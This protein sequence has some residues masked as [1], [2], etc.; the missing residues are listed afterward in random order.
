MISLIVACDD[1]N[2]IGRNNEIPWHLSSDLK[3]FKS[4]TMGNTIIMG[5][6]TWLSL[7]VKPL[8][9]RKNIVISSS[10]PQTDGC[11]VCRNID[12]AFKNTNQ[13]ENIF[14][15]GGASIYNQTMQYADELIVTHIYKSFENTD[16]FFPEI[17]L[18][19]WIISEQSD[20]FHDEKSNLNYKYITYKRI[21]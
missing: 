4:I 18:S 11:I 16:A 17:K 1:N 8:K 2:A 5:K 10:M 13:E 19:E 6:K 9:G 7:P 14:I 3:R 15:I 12:E 21:R 20:V